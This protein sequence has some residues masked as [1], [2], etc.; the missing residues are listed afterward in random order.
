[1][2]V[3]VHAREMASGERFAFGCNWAAFLGVLDEDR[4]EEAVA[5]LRA[6]LGDDSL[7][8]RTFLDAGSGSGLFS[9]A[10]MR[11]GADRVHSFDFDPASVA[12]AVEL[13]KRYYPD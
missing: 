11:L 5:S 3:D 9:L 13:R 12:C 6:M 7:E 1:M 4:I 2:T 10:A 8:G